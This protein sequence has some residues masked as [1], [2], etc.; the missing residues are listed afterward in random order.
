MII[1]E[2]Y[3]CKKR[4]KTKTGLYYK[5]P[6]EVRKKYLPSFKGFVTP[7]NKEELGIFVCLVHN[8]E[9]FK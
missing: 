6:D 1:R 5:K 9:H 7:M 8:Y 4:F 3:V 2:C